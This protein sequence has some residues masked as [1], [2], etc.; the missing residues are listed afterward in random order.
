MKTLET[1]S[2]TTPS[3]AMPSRLPPATGIT[4]IGHP[5]SRRVNL[6]RAAAGDRIPIEVVSYPEWIRDGGAAVTRPQRVVRIES[7]SECL[8]TFHAI[9]RAGIAPMEAR[10]RI[11]LSESEI[12]DL[13]PGKGEILHPLQWFL[14]LRE[15]MGNL[16]AAWEPHQP[17]WMTAPSAVTRM[18]DKRATLAAWA[19]SRLPLPKQ[20]PEFKT[21][22][23]LREAV[24][25]PHA[26]LFV[27]LRYGYSA[28]GAVALEW[29]G[30][31]IRAITTVDVAWSNG[32]PRLFVSKKPR[33]L[34]R[35]FE[36]AWLIDTLG[37]EEILVENWLPKACWNRRNFDLRVITTRGRVTHL[38]GRASFSPFTNLNLDAQRIP[39]PLVVEHLGEHWERAKALCEQA[40]REF[41]D[42]LA[43]GIDLLVKP[44]GQDFVLLEANAFGDYLPGLT[45]SGKSTYEMQI[46]C[47]RAEQDFRPT[48]KGLP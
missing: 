45:A 35:E 17:R 22:S 43:M 36:I 29:R 21:Y 41:P 13:T 48:P 33:V 42:A 4:L 18:F 5:A 2:K 46:Q 11:P 14:G 28:M 20:Y 15:L 7:P 16:E 27:K 24:G 44:S 39:G 38:V 37:M 12:A 23:Q 3:D 1:T 32:R 9:L 34:T 40:S 30:P 31:L 8:G 26:R 6:F 25:S 10:R 47:L 19:S